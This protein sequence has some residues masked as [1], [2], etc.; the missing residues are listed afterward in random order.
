MKGTRKIYEVKISSLG[1]TR[2]KTPRTVEVMLKY[3]SRERW[4]ELK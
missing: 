3:C 4:M 2:Q 1:E